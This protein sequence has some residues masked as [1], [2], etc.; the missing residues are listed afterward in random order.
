AV[1]AVVGEQARTAIAQ[2]PAVRRTVIDPLDALRHAIA[3]AVEDLDFAEEH[4]PTLD[5]SSAVAAA[6]AVLP[7]FSLMTRCAFKCAGKG[8]APQWGAA[9]ISTRRGDSAAAFRHGRYTT[10]RACSAAIVTS[11]RRRSGSVTH[12]AAP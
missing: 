4:D 2:L 8:G 6:A 3:V 1:C 7:A 9:C 12:C 10:P 11:P 5:A